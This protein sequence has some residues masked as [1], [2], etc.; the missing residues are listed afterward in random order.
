M[1]HIL[2]L[3][4]WTLAYVAAT[5]VTAVAILF[6]WFLFVF[7]VLGDPECDRGECSALGE[8]TDENWGLLNVLALS[9]AALLVALLLR[10]FRRPMCP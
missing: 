6:S 1:R 10:R 8:F 7:F 5:L 2:R 3:V 4:L 9:I